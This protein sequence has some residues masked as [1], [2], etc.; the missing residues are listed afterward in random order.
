MKLPAYTPTVAAAVL[1]V[2]LAVVAVLTRSA[3]LPHV[4]PSNDH[5]ADGKAGEHADEHPADR[6]ELS[7]QAQK[8]LGLVAETLAPREYWRKLVI[9]GVVV[10]RP[11]DSDRTVAARVSGIVAEIHARPG[12]TVKPGATLFEFELVSE[13]LQSSQVELART[14]T[15][16]ALAVSERDR[17]ANLVKL[18]TTPA[19]DLIRQQNQVDRLTNLARSLRRQLQLFG[20]SA[21]QVASAEAGDVVTRAAVAAP[22]ADGADVLYE[23]QDLKVRPGEQVQAG[24][25][26][27]TLA[28]HRKLFVEGWA[29][30]TESRALAVAAEKAVKVE[31]EFTDENP[32]EW[33]PVPPL[34]IHHLAN[35]VDPVNRTF[36]FYLALQNESR[37][38]AR[39][40]KT[41][42]A[43][44]FRPGQRVRLR[45]P[46]EKL[47]TPGPG[48]KKVDPFVLPAGAVVREGPEA[49]VFVQAGDLFIRRPVRVLYQDSTEAVV[50]NDGSVTRAE[51]VV[52]NQAAAINR[53]LKAQGAEPGGH[54]HHDH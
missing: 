18:G 43:W 13:V 51:L 6:I 45:L 14:A 24:Q 23:V 41:Y 50:A 46:V 15:D 27:A 5:A 30:K 19:A 22:P 3:W 26:L 9:P 12:D 33:E 1:V 4:F 36:P 34:T 20:L 29:F 31:V 40:G 16:L 39:D 52:R 42:L 21:E 25:A 53:A 7:E 10:D 38:I 48:G 47:A 2:G 54:H 49:F 8:N 11:G 44:R 32:G 28:D 17:L 35:S 37:T